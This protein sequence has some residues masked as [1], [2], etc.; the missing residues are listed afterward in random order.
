MGADWNVGLY[1]AKH[2]FVWQ[3]GRDLLEVLAPQAGE[4]VLDVG[5]GTGRLSAEI[6]SSGAEVLG[7]DYSPT[8]VSQARANFPILSFETQDACTMPYL[9]EFHAVFSNA[10][11]HWMQ[12]AEQAAAA[13]SRALK[14]GGRLVAEF[15]GRGNIQV[16]VNAAYGALRQ[17]GI[18]DPERHNPWYFPSVG[19]YATLLE[20]AGLEVTL[21][22]MFDRPT[23]LEGGDSS[24]QDWFTV[25]G[26]RL[27]EGLPPARVPDFMR[28][29]EDYAAPFLFRD[30]QWIADYRRLRIV[31][32]KA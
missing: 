7:I 20:R 4:R 14:P 32:R 9:G 2:S 6:A 11:L 1:E 29:V 24:L 18:A 17:L 19:E 22:A 12:P 26:A 31:A 5:C 3:F 27:T 8:M 25:F 16:L 28:L 15:G 21:A 30:G 23:P 10:A 13:M